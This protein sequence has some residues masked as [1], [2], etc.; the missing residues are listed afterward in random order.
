MTKD[1]PTNVSFKEGLKVSDLFNVL[2]S[3][4]GLKLQM[5][6]PEAWKNVEFTP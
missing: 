3:A 2:T 1:E 6:L 5:A 4:F